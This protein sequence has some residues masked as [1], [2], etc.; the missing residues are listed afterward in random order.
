V[1]QAVA[2]GDPGLAALDPATIRQLHGTIRSLPAPLLAWFTKAFRKRFADQ[3]PLTDNRRVNSCE[4][5][6]I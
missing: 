6:P 4:L 2:Q 1:A 5:L 3:T